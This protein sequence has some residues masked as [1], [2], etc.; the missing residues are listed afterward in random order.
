MTAELAQKLRDAVTSGSMA[1]ISAA[2]ALWVRPAI[3]DK[4]R[5]KTHN[6]DKNSCNDLEHDL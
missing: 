3:E 5:E 1:E 2:V 6:A 4:E